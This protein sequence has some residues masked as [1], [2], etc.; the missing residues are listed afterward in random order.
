RPARPGGLRAAA[1]VTEGINAPNHTLPVGR[2]GGGGVGT[3]PEGW[4]EGPTTPRG[5][6]RAVRE[7]ASLGADQAGRWAVGRRDVLRTAPGVSA[8]RRER[9]QAG[10]K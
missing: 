1:S 7:G 2:G 4:S 8:A 9:P 6:P 10:S 3:H 5:P